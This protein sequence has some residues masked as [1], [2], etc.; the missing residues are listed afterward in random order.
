MSTPRAVL[1]LS[2]LL[3]APVAIAGKKGEP[4]QATTE[5][6]RPS[7]LESY[8]HTQ[9][10]SMGKHMKML[11]MVAKGNVDVPGDALAHAQALHAAGQSLTVIFP[12]GDGN[13]K[14]D[15]D[16]EGFEDAAQAYIDA[17]AALV[18]A[19]ESGDMA[20]VKA[21]MSGVGPTCGACHD[22]YRVD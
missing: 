12:E 19:A 14:I 13:P 15:A 4:K 16:R 2:I 21:A 6:A 3:L 1:A 17:T 11:S 8:R 9:M 10:E 18:Q 22:G 7:E 20:S 5:E